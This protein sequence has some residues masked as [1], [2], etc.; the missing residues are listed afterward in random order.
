MK[1]LPK[2][3]ADGWA[4]PFGTKRQ[5]ESVQQT[6]T[7]H[8][9]V[10]K[11]RKQKAATVA[12][13]ELLGNAAEVVLQATA[14]KAAAAHPPR[15]VPPGFVL[16]SQAPARAPAPTA[17]KTP[18]LVPIPLAA[19]ASSSSSLPPP[20]PQPYASS[21]SSLPSPPPQPASPAAPPKAANFGP[22]EFTRDDPEGWK[23]DGW[24]APPGE[25]RKSRPVLPP[26]RKPVRQP[27]S[28]EERQRTAQRLAAETAALVV[29]AR[30]EGRYQASLPGVASTP[31]LLKKCYWFPGMI[32]TVDAFDGTFS[33]LYD[34]GDFEEG[35]RR[36]WVRILDP[37]VAAEVA[38]EAEKLAQAAFDELDL[39][40]GLDSPDPAE[41][42]GV[43]FLD[44]DELPNELDQG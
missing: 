2:W 19:S 22:R 4:A 17:Q 18:G 23:R 11:K 29:G 25:M 40:N 34:D 9:E 37:K 12:Q 36:R 13:N 32:Q 8:H 20:P 28:E 1:D 26:E 35:V 38:S 31:S 15:A 14:Q 24:M 5:R 21:S 43:D 30:V 39:A 27:R 44:D 6:V 33:I 42:F 7:L 10:L 41:E 3:V 16:K